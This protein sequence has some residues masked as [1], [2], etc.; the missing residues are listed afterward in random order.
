MEKELTNV[1]DEDF[2]EED[3]F[4]D[5]SSEFALRPTLLIQ[6]DEDKV[7]IHPILPDDTDPYIFGE[8]LYRMCNDQNF[9]IQILKSLHE[10]CQ[11]TKKLDLYSDIVAIWRKLTRQND[12]VVRPTEVFGG[13]QQ[14]QSHDG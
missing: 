1:V 11:Q 3:E 6:L 5:E 12:V 8:M 4:D 10:Y 2:D 13:M 9:A 14:E 7:S